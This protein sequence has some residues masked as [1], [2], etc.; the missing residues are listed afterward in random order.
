LE[1][2]K[3]LVSGNGHDAFVVVAFFHFPRHERVTDIAVGIAT[4]RSR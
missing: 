2:G 4:L 3:G 1:G